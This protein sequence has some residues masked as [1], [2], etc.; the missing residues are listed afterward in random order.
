VGDASES[1]Q[2]LSLLEEE[3]SH[4]HRGPAEVAPPDRSMEAVHNMDYRQQGEIIKP[5]FII[6]KYSN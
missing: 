3:T 2:I 6:E 4:P 5:Q 1:S